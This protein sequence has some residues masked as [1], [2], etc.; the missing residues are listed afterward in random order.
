MLS[1]ESIRKNIRS[2][3]DLRDIVKTMRTLA[4]VNIHHFEQA[5]RSLGDYY[6]SIEMGF[7]VVLKDGTMSALEQGSTKGGTY[8]IVFGTDQGLCGGFNDQIADYASSEISKEKRAAEHDV[9]VCMGERARASL[10]ERKL[11]VTDV[12][13]LPGGLP[14]IT[15]SVQQTVM[16]ITDLQMKGEISRVALFYHKLTSQI[17]YH[18]QTVILLPIDRAWTDSIQ[19]KKWPTHVLPAFTIERENLF[20]ALFRQYIFVSLFRA[21]AESMASENAARLMSMQSAEKNIEERLDELNAFYRSERQ[22]AITSELLDIV[23]GFE[24]LREEV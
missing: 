19:K 11:D 10:E 18:P 5:V 15:L 20:S 8:Y 12:Y 2:A 6:R 7:Q 23:S 22:N 4:A 21:F 24:A 17:T 3:E 1:I 14:G 9:L 13:P 16:N